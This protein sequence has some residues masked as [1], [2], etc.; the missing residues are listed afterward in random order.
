LDYK[1]ETGSFVKDVRR[2]IDAFLKDRR[3]KGLSPK[4]L[5]NHS[6]ILNYFIDYCVENSEGASLSRVKRQY[7]LDFLDWRA[8]KARKGFA[9]ESKNLYVRTIK[10]LFNFISD[11]NLKEFDYT[12]MLRKI[13]IKTPKRLPK[14]LVGDEYERLENYLK[15]LSAGKSNKSNKF[16]NARNALIIKV[17]LYCGLRRQEIVDL[18][19]DDIVAVQFGDQNAYRLRVIGKGDKERLVYIQKKYIESE[20][21]SLRSRGAKAIAETTTGRRLCPH[22]IFKIASKTLS[23]A[24]INKSGVHL[25]RHTY[26]IKCID[27]DINLVTLQESLGHSNIKTTMVYA[28]SNDKKKLEAAFR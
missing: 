7:I 24:G 22:H 10:A 1:L 4:T 3:A 16:L 26:A 5:S 27:K 13:S 12:R 11:N 15:L 20:L 17:L 9:Q 23:E 28:R 6:D 18:E 2:W 25:L 19:F 21:E 14:G 8:D